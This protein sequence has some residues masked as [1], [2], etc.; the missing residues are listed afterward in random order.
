[1]VL[2]YDK[3]LKLSSSAVNRAAPGRSTLT[4]ASGEGKIIKRLYTAETCPPKYRDKVLRS[5]KDY[6]FENITPL[7]FQLSVPAQRVA[8]R[9]LRISRP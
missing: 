8:Y 5:R 2:K 7:A 4:A 3:S 9:T 1:M 6:R